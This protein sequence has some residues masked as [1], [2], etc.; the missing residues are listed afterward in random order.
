[1]L[2]IRLDSSES[3]ATNL[4]TSLPRLPN[5]TSLN[6][7]IEDDSTSYFATLF[8]TITSSSIARTLEKLRLTV[9]VDMFNGPL[10]EYPSFEKL[11]VLSLDIDLR[12][13]S[14]SHPKTIFPP[15]PSSFL[16]TL[17]PTLQRLRISDQSIPHDLCP[18]FDTLS[19]PFSPNSP[20]PFPHLDTLVL[21]F[22]FDNAEILQA[23]HQSLL[24]F[25]LAHHNDLRYLHLKL[26]VP[27]LNHNEKHLGVWLTELAN[28]SQ[29]SSLR[30]LGIYPSNTPAGLSAVLALIKRTA[31]TLTSLTIY[32]HALTHED[33]ARVLDALT[34]REVRPRNFKNLEMCILQLSV[35]FLDL[36][37]CKL[38]QLEKLNLWALDVVGSNQ[39]FPSLSPVH[40][41][42][43]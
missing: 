35:P 1:M 23:S 39:V 5:I 6:I 4:L 19:E 37:A 25:L 42:L 29:F 34:E 36:L 15:A 38:L 11:T 14:Q 30:T 21:F 28:N 12:R 33:A 2:T 20:I 26:T 32:D 3:V 8:Q 7:T 13:W 16:R 22:H 43:G 9:C 40:P 18:L 41:S 17:A 31:P 10:A 24:R 27:N